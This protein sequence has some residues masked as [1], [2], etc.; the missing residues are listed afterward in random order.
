MTDENAE[1]KIRLRVNGIPVEFSAVSGVI[2]DTK[3]IAQSET[4]VS[5]SGGG[6]SVTVGNVT[7]TQP[8]T[9]SS[10]TTH[11]T[12]DTIFLKHGESEMSFQVTNNPMPVRPGNNLT[13]IFGGRPNKGRRAVGLY[14]HDTGKGYVVGKL[15]APNPEILP[16]LMMFGLAFPVSFLFSS[17]NGLG[18]QLM[19]T[20]LIGLFFFAGYARLFQHV[21]KSGSEERIGKILRCIKEGN[22][23]K[24]LEPA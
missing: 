21:F 3:Q 7:T 23:I 11:W 20:F 2:V 16:S 12:T 1:R 18:M 17:G 22:D 4:V 19:I 15:D 13:A 6:S 9:I 14:N 5:G 24:T 10:H 8:V